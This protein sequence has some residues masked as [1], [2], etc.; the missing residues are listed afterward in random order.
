MTQLNTNLTSIEIISDK[1]QALKMEAN[2]RFK[3]EYLG[4]SGFSPLSLIISSW[5]GIEKIT[6]CKASLE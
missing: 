2:S 6:A 4:W 5:D 1:K 3:H